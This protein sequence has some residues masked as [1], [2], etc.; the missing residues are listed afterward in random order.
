MEGHSVARLSDAPH[1]LPS[2]LTSSRCLPEHLGDPFDNGIDIAHYFEVPESQH[3]ISIGAQERA[4]AFILLSLLRVLR[5]INF[6]EQFRFQA[7]EV[8]EERT[9]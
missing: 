1:S 8:D 3:A 4:P 6:D 9:N 2:L 5:T 7:N